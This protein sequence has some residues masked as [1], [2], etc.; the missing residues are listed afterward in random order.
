MKLLLISLLLMGF[1]VPVAAQTTA[2]PVVKESLRDRAIKRCKENRGV[3]CESREGLREWLREE[4]PIS[5]AERTSAA[6]GRRHREQCA[7]N[8]KGA[9]C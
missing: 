2:K 5:D 6:A 3:D 9:N 4:R 7:K 1:S 8:P